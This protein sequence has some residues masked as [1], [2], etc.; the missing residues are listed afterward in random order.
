MAEWRFVLG[1]GR[2]DSLRGH[3]GGLADLYTAVRRVLIRLMLVDDVPT[4][5]SINGVGQGC[6]LELLSLVA[7]WIRNRRSNRQ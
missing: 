1:P 2:P 5:Q 4:P 7:A 3:G 6:N